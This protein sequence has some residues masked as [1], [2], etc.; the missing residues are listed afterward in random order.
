MMRVGDDGR[1]EVVR[2]A[3]PEDPSRLRATAAA[4]RSAAGSG[5]VDIVSF[6]DDGETLELV[7]AFAGRSPVAPMEASALARLGSALAGHVADLHAQ[8]MA[9]G[10]LVT[11]HVLVDATGAVRLCGFG[12]S[13][14]AT[15]ADDVLAIGGLLG[16]LLADGDV[17]ACATAIRA[18]SSR[19]AS[20]PSARPS[21]AAVAAALASAHGPRRAVA[22][23]RSS[24]RHR[25]WPVLPAIAAAL[26]VATVALVTVTHASRSPAERRTRA[27]APTSS[28]TSTSTTVR[29]ASRIWPP[30]PPTTIVGGGGRWTLGTSSD[31]SV[32]GDWDCDGVTTPALVQP[33]GD[34]WVIDSWPTGDE[35]TARF[36]TNV[37][38]LGDATVEHASGC[39]ALV[40]TTAD[41]HK[42]HQR[43]TPA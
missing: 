38:P 8:G 14:D 39:D 34:V 1:L 17:S 2:T 37:G 31:R 15:P 20:E 30:G 19:C 22:T 11:E 6:T 42:V 21:M 9:H 36:V 12:S 16:G 3:P 24:P 7:L 29:H 5:S 28:T 26:V 32:L 40:I 18:T 33:T 25:R 41:G 4:M 13:G 10:A 27:A 43:L 23:P 35:A